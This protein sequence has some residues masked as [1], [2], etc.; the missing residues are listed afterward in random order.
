MFKKLL[1]PFILLCFYQTSVMAQTN[2]CLDL[3]VD[4]DFAACAGD[5]GFV[6][7]SATNGIPPYNY[8]G[9]GSV[10]G[11]QFTTPV[12]LGPLDQGTYT[13]VVMDSDTCDADA[14]FTIV[15]P[16]PITI[17][18]VLV[19]E[20]SCFAND[21]AIVIETFGG[22]PP[23]TFIWAPGGQTTQNINN[24]G[25][26]NYTVTVTDNNNC[27]AVQTVLVFGNDNLDFSISTIDVLCNGDANGSI[28]AIVAPG[29]GFPPYF[30]VWDNGLG[31]L[32]S[33]IITG[34]PA[35]TYCVTITDDSNCQ[36]SGCA[37]ITEPQALLVDVITIDPSPGTGGQITAIAIGGTPPIAYEWNNGSPS[38]T[39]TDLP[40]GT[41]TVTVTDSNGCVSEVDVLLQ[42]SA[43]DFTVTNVD[44]NGDNTGAIDLD[45]LATLPP[46]L[47][48]LWQGPGGFTS[49][50]QNI[51]NLFAGTYILEITDGNNETN[52]YQVDVLESPQIFAVVSLPFLCHGDPLVATITVSGGTAPY[53]FD[54]G[55]LDPNDLP[56]G[57]YSVTVTDASNCTFVYNDVASEP[58]EIVITYTV[59]NSTCNGA[60]GCIE[61]VVTGGVPGYTYTWSNGTT[62]PTI[63]GLAAGTYSL[64]VNDANGCFATKDVEVL[65]IGGPIV[66]M[67][68]STV[69]CDME[70]FINVLVSGSVPLSFEWSDD[71]N[72]TTQNRTDLGPGIYTVTVT[73]VNDCQN[74]SSFFIESSIQLELSTMAAGCDSTG[75]S[76]TVIVTGGATNPTY[77]WS[78]SETT[79]S[80]LNLAP[81]G[82]SVTVTDPGPGCR[83]HENVIVPLDSFCF[84]SISGT[85]YI[86][87]VNQDCVPDAGAIGA[88]GV[89]VTL[90]NGHSTFTDS[91][92]NYFFNEEPGIYAVSMV[93][94]NPQYDALCAGPISVDVSATMSSSEDNDFFV[95]Y[96]IDKD[97]KIYVN[98]GNA[99]PGFTQFIQICVWNFGDSPA[100][101]T[102]TFVH[103]PI[104]EFLSASPT[105]DSYDLATQTITWTFTNLAP[106]AVTVFYPKVKLDQTVALGTPLNLNFEVTPIV[107]DE[108]PWNN[109]IHCPMVVTGSY[110]PNDKLVTPGMGEFGT[111]YGTDTLLTY[112][113]R[114]QNTGTDTAFTVVIKDTLEMGLDME[115]LVPGP[116][117][118]SY[119]LT[120]EDERTLV[121]TFDNIML[122]DSFV[123]E[124]ASNGFVFF[125]IRPIEGTSYGTVIENSAAIYFDFNLPIITNTA[126]TTFDINVNTFKPEDFALPLQVQPNPSSGEVF[127]SYS[128]EESQAVWINVYDMQGRFIA[129]LQRKQKL[130][131]GKHQLLIPDTQLPGGVYFIRIETDQKLQGISKLIKLD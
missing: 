60:N 79:Q 80:I 127:L 128:L 62:T 32:T 112:R 73:D 55:G 90:D 35:G 63:C 65:E 107:G 7:L 44:C 85:V 111:I 36:S 19:Q 49:T 98:K 59:N 29:S 125:D 61:P 23:Y 76:A 81:G 54:W 24:L 93:S 69:V 102:L 52:G 50:E 33:P 115:T 3:Q 126:T 106:G 124:P 131:A 117:S 121:F 130:Q 57:P 27:T 92:G 38:N 83:R 118:H 30:Y 2:G 122:P 6:T 87:Q 109:T 71:P 100:D 101:G 116:A 97:L 5:G 31:G 43:V 20:A 96:A 13:I 53:T 105:E 75:G 68:G 78:T 47:T 113:I 12:T 99:R 9:F 40:A 51:D 108:T 10:P 21:G 72:I 48:F 25:Q 4:V 16:V 42:S 22:T 67:S 94:N 15:E 104:Q 129:N 46:P 70:G 41:Y 89:L 88:G 17:D 119:E 74:I 84:V 18:A 120:V 56:V 110:D 114:F 34:L 77:A 1:L 64:T 58:E 8:T 45:I 11:G 82:Y 91:D 37:V 95:E 26:G 123:N 28:E 86:E 14:V 66:M 39:I 103:D